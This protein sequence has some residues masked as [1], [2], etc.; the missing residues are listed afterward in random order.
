VKSDVTV[1]IPTIP[2]RHV[3]LAQAV[4][5]V[6]LQTLPAS[7]ISI[8]VDTDRRGAWHT[9]QRAVDAVTTDWI[10]FL[11]DDDLF[12][13]Q[14]IKRLRKCAQESD[15]DYVFS[16]WDTSVTPDILGLFGRP[17]DPANPTHTTMTVMVKTELA[18]VV[19]FTARA[20]EHVAGGEDWRFM[21]GCVDVGARIV[22]LPEQTWIWRHHSGN[23]S[24][25]EDRW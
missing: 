23:T 16:Y 18:R 13:P 12:K 4:Q 11:D 21:L 8:A 20:P 15:A 24:G 22:H 25:R 5:S 3:M 1:C 14:H 7:A 9:R 6:A 10:A 2:P 19:R 17:F